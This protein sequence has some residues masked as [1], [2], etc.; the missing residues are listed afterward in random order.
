ML[1]SCSNDQ[2]IRVWD[3]ANYKC[4][5]EFTGHDNVI[6]NV[7]FSTPES[8]PYISQLTNVNVNQH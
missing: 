7:L 1:V 8:N 4:K 6:E 3:M 2:T 5:S